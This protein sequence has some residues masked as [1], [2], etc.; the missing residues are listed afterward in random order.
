[1]VKSAQR[2]FDSAV[3]GWQAHYVF[4][5]HVIDAS[6]KPMNAESAAIWKSRRTA[7]KNHLDRLEQLLEQA[8]R[9]VHFAGSPAAIELREKECQQIRAEI[10]RF[11]P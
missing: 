8:K 6:R 10:K 1:M 7:V 3:F 11:G 9:N 4:C 2:E 5:D